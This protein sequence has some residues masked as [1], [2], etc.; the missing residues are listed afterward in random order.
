MLIN[1]GEESYAKHPRRNNLSLSSVNHPSR[2]QSRGNGSKTVT[3]EFAVMVSSTHINVG[4]SRARGRASPMR[5]ISTLRPFPSRRGCSL[6]VWATWLFVDIF[7]E[8][9]PRI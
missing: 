5:E 3:L 8:L 1:H 4:F 7:T 9:R 2:K 6:G